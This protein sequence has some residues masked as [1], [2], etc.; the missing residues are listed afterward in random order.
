MNFSIARNIIV[1]LVVI[2]ISHEDSWWMIVDKKI[3][4][5]VFERLPFGSE[6]VTR[7]DWRGW[8]SGDKN[9]SHLEIGDVNGAV[10]PRR[11]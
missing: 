11:N 4:I 10:T 2:P 9:K 7:Y 6:N 8:E 5:A 1:P 3:V